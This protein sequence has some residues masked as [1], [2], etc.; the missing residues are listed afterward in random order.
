M[1][2]QQTPSRQPGV[3]VAV[4]GMR[5]WPPARSDAHAVRRGVGGPAQGLSL[6]VLLPWWCVLVG[7][8]SGWSVG[9]GTRAPVGD[10]AGSAPAGVARGGRCCRWPRG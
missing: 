5:P 8:L 3:D 10:R 7:M 6:V 1:D 2:L 4:M 9:V